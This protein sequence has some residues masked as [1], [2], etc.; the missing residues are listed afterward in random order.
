VSRRHA[1]EKASGQGA[2][3]L[4]VWIIASVLGCV[5]GAATVAGVVAYQNSPYGGVLV[6]SCSGS[7]RIAG[8]DYQGVSSGYLTGF[9]GA[10]PTYCESQRVSP[11]SQFSISLHLHSND[12]SEN[13]RILGLAAQAP[14]TTLDVSPALPVSISASGNVT[15]EL[16]LLVPVAGGPYYPAVTVTAD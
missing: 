12:H 9:Y 1:E 4:P 7:I 11:G 8:F 14:F 6:D 13:H 3:G 16:T 10:V 5:V 15:L 2:A